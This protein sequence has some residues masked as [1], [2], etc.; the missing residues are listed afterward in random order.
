MNFSLENRDNFAI[1]TILDNSVEGKSAAEL[2]TKILV[3]AQT[4]IEAL[5][6]DLS[7]VSIMDSSGLGAL[8]LAHRQLKDHSIP[9]VLVGVQEFIKNL[10][11]ITRIED[12]FIYFA[13]VDDALAGIERRM[14]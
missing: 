14:K 1:I 5:I 7:N 9:V 4:N 8:L 3:V 10:L 6:L 11:N 12:I 2:K 13:T